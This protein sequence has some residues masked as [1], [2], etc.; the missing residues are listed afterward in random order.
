MCRKFGEIAGRGKSS[1]ERSRKSENRLRST[2]IRNGEMHDQPDRRAVSARG[3]AGLGAFASGGCGLSIDPAAVFEAARL[4][5]RA[6][7]GDAVPHGGH[8]GTGKESA[9]A[10][11]MRMSGKSRNVIVRLL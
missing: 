4:Y 5:H 1:A 7:A 3:H 9:T 10:A 11:V 6:V 8:V 2:E